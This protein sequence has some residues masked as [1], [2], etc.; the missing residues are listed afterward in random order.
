MSEYIKENFE[1]TEDVKER[2][3][4]MRHAP[5]GIYLGVTYN[6]IGRSNERYEMFQKM[7]EKG[8]VKEESREEIDHDERGGDRFVYSLT[9][10]GHG[11]GKALQFEIDKW[12]VKWPLKE[13]GLREKTQL[14]P[15]RILPPALYSK[16]VVQNQ[17]K[18]DYSIKKEVI[19][20]EKTKKKK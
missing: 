18:I 8:L 16:K 3:L 2:L 13:R 19:W 20:W 15:Y 11:I 1:N 6:R 7:L 10:L 17:F 14:S 12:R 5:G 9:P 4:D